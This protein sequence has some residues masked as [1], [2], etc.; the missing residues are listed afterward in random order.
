MKFLGFESSRANP[1]VSM[2]ESI[3]KYIVTKYYG[4]VLLYTSE[5][6]VMNNRGEPVLRNEIEKYFELK[7]SSNG[8][9]LQYLGG[10]LRMV[11]V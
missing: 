6:L 3:R 5:G 8:A 9:P 10:K 11:E 4:Y 1:N 7:E 2:R